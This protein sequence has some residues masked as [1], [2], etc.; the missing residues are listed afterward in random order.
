MQIEILNSK[1]MIPI[2]SCH[3]HSDES[4][5]MIMLKEFTLNILI[6][7]IA[8][9]HYLVKTRG[10]ENWCGSV[11]KFYFFPGWPLN[12]HH[13]PNDKILTSSMKQSLICLKMDVSSTY[14]SQG[15]SS[16][17]SLTFF[18]VEHSNPLDKNFDP[19]D[20]E[21]IP[22]QKPGNDYAGKIKQMFW[23]LLIIIFNIMI[24]WKPF[25]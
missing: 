15:F 7:A 9:N 11:I 4:S 24:F 23:E 13:F 8:A 16:N 17:N 19:T 22:I 10:F 18:P 2:K 20:A 1:E 12:S 21:M 3:Y 25:F 6:S 5:I 14:I